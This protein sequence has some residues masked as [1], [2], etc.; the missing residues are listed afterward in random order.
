M[1]VD[2]V[3]LL[4][5]PVAPLENLVLEEGLQETMDPVLQLQ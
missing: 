2:R 3:Q 4:L 5:G 1:L